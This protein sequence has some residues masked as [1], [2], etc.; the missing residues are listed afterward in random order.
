[1]PAVCC[2]GS[3]DSGHG[4]FSP[5]A[6]VNGNPLFT[7]NGIAITGTGG[8]SVIHAAPNVPPHVGSI[9]GTSLLTVNGINVAVVGDVTACGAVVVSGMGLMTI[10]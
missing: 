4:P 7:I 9:L 8:I 5:A 2:V 6:V 3:V 10:N 1:M